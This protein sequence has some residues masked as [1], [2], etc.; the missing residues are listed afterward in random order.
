M[1]IQSP[2]VH[3]LYYLAVGKRITEIPSHTT[4]DDFGLIMPPLE[5]GFR[6]H[7]RQAELFSLVELF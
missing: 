4:Q 7:Q 1:D 6:I 2:L 5:G 3:H